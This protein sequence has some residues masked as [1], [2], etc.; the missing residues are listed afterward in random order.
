MRDLLLVNFVILPL[1]S[2]IY[3]KFAPNHSRDTLVGN[4]QQIVL[5]PYYISLY[6]SGKIRDSKEMSYLWCGIP[7]TYHRF[8]VLF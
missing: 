1:I 5:T 8:C 2:E 6:G 3:R 7:N 4:V